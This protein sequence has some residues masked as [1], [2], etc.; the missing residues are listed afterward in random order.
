MWKLSKITQKYYT[1][2]CENSKHVA[3]KKILLW[4]KLESS[5][6]VRKNFHKK[7]VEHKTSVFDEGFKIDKWLVIFVI[8]K[9][10]RAY[11]LDTLKSASIWP[12]NE[13]PGSTYEIFNEQ[14]DKLKEGWYQTIKKSNEV[15]TDWS[16]RIASSICSE[17]TFCL[18]VVHILIGW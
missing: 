12:F 6:K 15:W 18:C 16:T 10:N 3:S 14:T 1:F 7:K 17:M 9:F 2:L 8:L 5:K 13:Q 4:K 11:L